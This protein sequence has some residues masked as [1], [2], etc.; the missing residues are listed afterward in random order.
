MLY[1]LVI[2]LQR[3]KR[4][5][6]S[7]EIIRHAVALRHEEELHATFR[8]WAAFEEALAGNSPA[9]AQHLAT[10]TSENAQ[11]KPQ[12]LRTMTELLIDLHRQPAENGKSFAKIIRDRLRKAFE[13]RRPCNAPRYV[14]DGYR[15]FISKAAPQ[16][17]GLGFKLWGWWY[18]R[19]PVWF[20]IPAVALLITLFVL[21]GI[22]MN[23]APLL[24]FGVVAIFLTL[25][26][27]K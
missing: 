6:E 21:G 4:F 26:R 20:L 1:N 16:A 14:R 17:G 12:P 13:K 5:A 7:V 19:G 9:A 22:S 3:Q 24:S 11:P 23:Q 8:L 2:M 25:S 15:R 18:Y 10:L 27:R